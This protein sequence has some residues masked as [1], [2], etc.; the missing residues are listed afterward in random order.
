MCRNEG[1]LELRAMRLFIVQTMRYTT[2]EK[3]EYGE[4]VEAVWWTVLP[5]PCSSIQ[6][7][8]TIPQ[9]ASVRVQPM[10]DHEPQSHLEILSR[11]RVNRST[12][13]VAAIPVSAFTGMLA[14]GLWK[15]LAVITIGALILLA[16]TALCAMCGLAYL[17]GRW[18]IDLRT[19]YFRSTYIYLEE[20]GVVDAM[21]GR[22]YPLA[23]PEPVIPG[24]QKPDL[25]AQIHFKNA[26]G[27]SY[28][29]IA[30][31]LGVTKYEV[32]KT[33]NVHRDSQAKNGV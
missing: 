27:D 31:A 21:T 1:P 24:E 3:V 16:L 18:Y 2:I 8:L 14:Y 10:N 28:R 5:I 9:T 22:I 29:T 25:A 23:L 26:Q 13:L 12:I 6:S 17:V 20:H 32:E 19:R 11:N 7:G 4:R 33:I 30:K 15:F